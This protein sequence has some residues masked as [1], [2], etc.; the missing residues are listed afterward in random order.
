MNGAGAVFRREFAAWF[1][2]PPGYVFLAVFAGSAGATTFLI[3]GFFPRGQADLQ[4]FFG[5]LPWLLVVFVPAVAMRLWAEER[6]SGT[7]ELLLSRPV[8]PLAAVT[9]KLFA[10]WAFVALGLAGT[11]PLWLTVAW[12]G[13]PDPGAIA[14]GYAGA[15]LLAGAYLALGSAISALTDSQVVAFVVAVTACFLSTAAGSPL[16]VGLA[17]EGTPAVVL[18]ALAGFSF[19]ARYDAL[20]R[21]LVEARDLVFFLSAIALAV[22][23]NT[24][25]VAR[26][27]A[28]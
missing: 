9:G 14:A 26:L 19:L 11:L 27:R 18:E 25:A 16:A 1:A 13:D 7:V 12:L 4:V 21:G 6:R 20:A 10:A 24:L 17:G 22:F 5:F 2:T 15:L 3:G 8:G 28:A 23:A